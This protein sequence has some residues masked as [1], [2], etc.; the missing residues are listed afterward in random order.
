MFLVPIFIPSDRTQQQNGE[1]YVERAV[2]K[3]HTAPN[4]HRKQTIVTAA[5]NRSAIAHLAVIVYPNHRL[6]EE[7]WWQHTHFSESNTN[8]EQLWLNSANTDT[9]FWSGIQW[10][11]G[12]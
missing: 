7:G 11:D 2:K 12:Q 9:N 8:G 1:V 5:L 3:V 10:L 4:S 6:Y